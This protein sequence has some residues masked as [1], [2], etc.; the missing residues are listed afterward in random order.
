MECR[1]EE[2]PGPWAI[3]FVLMKNAL[4]T[5]TTRCQDM[6]YACLVLCFCLTLIFE[7]QVQ[8]HIWTSCACDIVWRW[9]DCSVWERW[10]PLEC[11]EGR[12]HT[13]R[14]YHGETE[15][16]RTLC[17]FVHVSLLLERVTFPT[18]AILSSPLLFL[19]FLVKVMMLLNI[20]SGDL[21]CTWV[22]RADVILNSGFVKS[23]MTSLFWN[24]RW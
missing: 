17:W 9:L 3:N 18:D 16:H 19:L 24:E 15:A 8:L 22:I 10:V 4:M 1:E 7:L 21:M 23:S 12:E 13:E 11:S 5:A 14:G 2:R 20:S 6:K